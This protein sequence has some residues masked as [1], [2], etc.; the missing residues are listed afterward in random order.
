MLLTTVGS[1]TMHQTKQ[2]YFLSAFLVNSFISL[3]ALLC[4]ESKDRTESCCGK[5]ARVIM[6]VMAQRYKSPLHLPG[7]STSTPAPD[8]QAPSY[9]ESITWVEAG[10][11]PEETAEKI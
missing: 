5:P 11:E 7:P 9:S 1:R 10:K 2:Y 3:A 8:S 4:L 6:T